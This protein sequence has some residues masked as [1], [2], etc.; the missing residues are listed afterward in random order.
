MD[1]FR[2]LCRLRSALEAFAVSWL[3]GNAGMAASA[4]SLRGILKALHEHARKG[5]YDAFHRVDMDFHRKLVADCEVPTLLQ[6][7]ELTNAALEQE[8]LAVKKKHW[9]S[10][11]ALYREHLLLLEVWSGG[12]DDAARQAT[13]QHLEVGWYRVQMDKGQVPA[14]GNEVDRTASF[15]STHYSGD[16]QIEWVARNIAFLSASQLTRRF[17][18]QFGVAPYAWLR[19]VRMERAAQLLT[20]TAKSV[21]TV[22]TEVGYK[23][24]SHFSRDFRQAFG[25]SPLTWRGKGAGRGSAISTRSVP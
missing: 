25:V 16:I 10:L 21:S 15:L 1:S 5:D 18:R 6:N 4:Q 12:D 19:R 22:S 3:R 2:D 7:W 13:H 24:A 8:I 11:M 20:A 9:P 23:N 17:H 14:E